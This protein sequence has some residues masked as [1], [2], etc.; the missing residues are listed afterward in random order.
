MGIWDELHKN[1][2]GFEKLAQEHSMD[3]GSRSLGGLLAEPITRHAIPKNLSEKAF[4]HLV[5]GDRQRS[6]PHPQAQ[7]WR[8][9]RPDPGGESVW[10]ILRREEVVPAAKGLSSEG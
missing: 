10:V 4:H 9:H 8:L 3:P 7:G 1:P 2:G 5:D 6:R